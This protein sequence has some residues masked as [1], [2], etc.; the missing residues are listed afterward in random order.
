L[1]LSGPSWYRPCNSGRPPLEVELEVFELESGLNLELEI[2]ERI[3]VALEL[4]E[5]VEV[6]VEVEVE[7]RVVKGPS[8]RPS[9]DTHQASS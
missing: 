8:M 6:E 9:L 2:V 7:L 3:E 5:P 4:V 1:H